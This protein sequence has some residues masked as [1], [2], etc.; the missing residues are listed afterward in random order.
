[1]QTDSDRMQISDSLGMEVED[2]PEED[3]KG[4]LCMSEV[5]GARYML[6]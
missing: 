3:Y 2:V 6:P 5:L 4:N 1:M